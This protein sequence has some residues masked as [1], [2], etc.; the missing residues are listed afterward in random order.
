MAQPRSAA[1]SSESNPERGFGYDVCILFPGHIR[2]TCLPNN[3]YTSKDKALEQ[4]KWFAEHSITTARC[5]AVFR[6]KPYDESVVYS[7][8]TPAGRNGVFA[9]PCPFAPP[10]SPKENSGTPSDPVPRPRLPFLF[11]PPGMFKGK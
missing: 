2:Y 4:A 6:H 7:H 9:G 8:T 11:P 1:S 5:V 3:R 10:D